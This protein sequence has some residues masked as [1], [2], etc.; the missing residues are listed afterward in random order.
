MKT[1][2]I[3]LVYHDC[4]LKKLIAK[5]RLFIIVVSTSLYYL[6]RLDEFEK[7]KCFL[8]NDSFKQ[9]I[10]STTFNNVSP[11][12]MNNVVKQAG[13]SN[14]NSRASFPTLNQPLGKSN[15]RDKKALSCI[16]PYTLNG[17]LVSLKAIKSLNT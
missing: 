12:Y 1:N 4:L 9:C 10:S 15:Y 8:I 16:A 5:T 3:T 2:L 17:V 13:H 11:T 6:Q 7:I 14:T